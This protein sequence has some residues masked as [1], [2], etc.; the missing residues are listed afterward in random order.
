[1][2]LRASVV[3][4]VCVLLFAVG[5]FTSSIRVLSILPGPTQSDQEYVTLTGRDP[6]TVVFENAV[7]A[8]GSDYGEEIPVELIPFSLSGDAARVPG[9]IRW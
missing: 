3:L 7:I 9:R 6:I 5:Q 1:M 2:W 4:V 8:L